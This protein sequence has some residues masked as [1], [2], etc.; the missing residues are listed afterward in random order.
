M[1]Y[2]IAN[3]VNVTSMCYCSKNPHRYVALKCFTNLIING[4]LREHTLQDLAGMYADMRLE[5][6][7]LATIDHPN[8]IKFLGLCVVSFSFLLE[9]APKGTLEHMIREYKLA[10]FPICPDA[11]ANTVL[12]VSVAIV[13]YICI[14]FNFINPHSSVI[15]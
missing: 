12:Q 10:G 11:I 4:K 14:L 7:K 13:L 8:I 6:N 3:S 1:Y 5:V 15:L 2:E 9:W